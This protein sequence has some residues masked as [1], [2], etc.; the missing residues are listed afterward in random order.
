MSEAVR[1]EGAFLR[2]ADG[3]RFMPD[4][5]PM[6]EL[7]PRDVVARAIARR[8]RPMGADVTLDLRHLD[9]AEVHRRVPDRRRRSAPSTG[10][11]WP[12]TRSR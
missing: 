6:A 2:D 4:E 10:S 1:G 12:A 9:P 11:T 5:H 8:A 7:G 3:H